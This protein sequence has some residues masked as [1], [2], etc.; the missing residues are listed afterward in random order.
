MDGI[1]LSELSRK[2][3]NLLI[4]FDTVAEA[5]SVKV[6]ASRLNLTQSALSHA[7]GRLRVMFDDP[8]FV[9][10]RNGFTLTTR[11]EQLVRPVRES[12]L[13]L[14]SL[15]KPSA[16]DPGT[17]TRAFRVGLCEL[18]AV[19]FGGSAIREVNTAAPKATIQ[20]ELFD[21]ASERR[22]SEGGLDVGVWPYTVAL[23]PLR[24]AELF[25][26]T[27]VGVL[28][29]SHPLAA[30]VGTNSIT[31]EDYLG[32]PHVQTLLY[33]A[34]RDDVTNALEALGLERHIAVSAATFA[35]SFPL[36]YNSPLIVTAPAAAA[37]AGLEVCRDLLVFQL[38]FAIAPLRYKMV[39]HKRNDQDP[40][41][42]W[43]R[44]VLSK[45]VGYVV[46]YAVAKGAKGEP[47]LDP[48]RAL[49]NAT[50]VPTR[51]YAGEPEAA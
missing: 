1:D 13:S 14:E 40:A 50:P 10:D 43:L 31:L 11:A 49:R 26:D 6:A 34:Q 8:L 46:D 36:L 35:P 33:G 28:H 2:N 45:V 3:L 5:R 20:L 32:F 9:R 47:P 29:A 15:L 25:S 44:G 37:L 22:L 42:T 24:S 17:A 21:H 48:H 39:W 19:L 41:L 23:N 18:S 12:L 30:K 27:Y 7:I 16:F 51:R 38:P 4:V